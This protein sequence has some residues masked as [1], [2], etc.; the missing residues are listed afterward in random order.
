MPRSTTSPAFG[1]YPDDRHSTPTILYSSGEPRRR[2]QLCVWPLY[3]FCALGQHPDGGQLTPAI[4]CS[5]ATSSPP[6]MTF[7]LSIPLVDIMM[8]KF[9]VFDTCFTRTSTTTSSSPTL[10]STERPSDYLIS[11][12][13]CPPSH[14]ESLRYHL[15]HLR[16]GFPRTAFGG[17]SWRRS[18]TPALFKAEGV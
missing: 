9:R 7:L 4:L 18:L 14:L 17:L 16:L 10:A 12:Y 1:R 2:P 15:L 8:M 11:S 13:T 5:R 3:I 6:T